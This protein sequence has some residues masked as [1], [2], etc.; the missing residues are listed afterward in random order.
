[1]INARTTSFLWFHELIKDEG[2][3]PD[4]L[5][6]RDAPFGKI[7]AADLLFNQQFRF[8]VL[9]AVLFIGNWLHPLNNTFLSFWQ[10]GLHFTL[11][12]FL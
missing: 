1:L 6:S 11:H 7:A 8:L 4:L 10:N 9:H 5:S 2:Q 3:Q 12:C